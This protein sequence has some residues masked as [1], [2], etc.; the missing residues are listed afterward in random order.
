[1]LY[2]TALAVVVAVASVGGIVAAEWSRRRR[3]AERVER[4]L[5]DPSR[6]LKCE[7]DIYFNR[8]YARPK[9]ETDDREGTQ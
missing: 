6:V 7:N 5:L 1:M 3:I 2:L 9:P 8:E 4:W